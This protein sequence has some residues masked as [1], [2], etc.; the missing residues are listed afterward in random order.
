M[1]RV[2]FSC[3][4]CDLTEFMDIDRARQANFNVENWVIHRINVHESG[5]DGYEFVAEL[6]PSCTANFRNTVNPANW[7][8]KTPVGKAPELEAA[9]SAEALLTRLPRRVTAF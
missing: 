7:R 9:R 8:K 2:Q 4:G 3:D 5:A 6:C 1:R